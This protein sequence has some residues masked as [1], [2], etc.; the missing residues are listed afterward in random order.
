MARF[1][2]RAEDLVVSGGY[3]NISY[4]QVGCERRHI[5][6]YP[7]S[8]PWRCRLEAPLAT[9]ERAHEDA[10]W[11]LCWHELGH[12]LATGSNDRKVRVRRLQTVGDGHPSN[13]LARTRVQFW[14]R[15]GPGSTIA[16]CNGSNNEPLEELVYTRHQPEWGSKFHRGGRWGG[17]NP[18]ERPTVAAAKAGEPPKAP[19]IGTAR[20][21][22]V[23]AGAHHALIELQARCALA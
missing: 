11:D 3:G 12:V 21:Q 1:H 20:A 17:V 5:D 10:I 15:P 2:P 18:Y 8:T 7:R 22:T 23:G 14:V 6:T 19:L 16:D 13:V 9:V 4:W